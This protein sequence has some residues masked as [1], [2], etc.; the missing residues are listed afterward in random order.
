M[1]ARALDRSSYGRETRSLRARN[2][3]LAWA[4]DPMLARDARSLHWRNPM[5]ARTRDPTL[6]RAMSGTRRKATS[7]TLEKRESEGA[8]VPSTATAGWRGANADLAGTCP[9][10]SSAVFAI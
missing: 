9:V 10:G 2:P 7:E 6:A 8:P 4:R 3:R 1:L 5:F